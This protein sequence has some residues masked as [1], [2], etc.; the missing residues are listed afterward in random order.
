MNE[1]IY[2]DLDLPTGTKRYPET[3]THVEVWD[4]TFWTRKMNHE[5][6]RYTEAQ[7]KLIYQAVRQ[8]QLK[9][10]VDG[11]AYRECAEILDALV[12]FVYTANHEQPT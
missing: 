10:P 12:P 3:G 6:P 5:Q 2:R 7:Q 8:W 11:S 1:L 9:F 4:G